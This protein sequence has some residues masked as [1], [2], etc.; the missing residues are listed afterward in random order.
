MFG[1]SGESEEKGYFPHGCANESILTASEQ[2]NLPEKKHF[3]PGR[4]KDKD[5]AEFETWYKEHEND[6]FH[7]ETWAKKYCRQDVRVLAK[8]C[9][10]FRDEI[11]E[12]ADLDPW[13]SSFTLANI[14]SKIFRAD[15]LEDNTIAVVPAHG[16]NKGSKFQSLTALKYLH[17]V[18]RNRGID[19]RTAT[20]VGGE[21]EI[22]G[23]GHVDGF[24]METGNYPHH[25]VL[26]SVHKSKFAAFFAGELHQ[27][28]M[29][30][31]TMPYAPMK[32]VCFLSL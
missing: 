28:R 26:C 1:F 2:P 24:C 30:H 18:S 22:P 32:Y 9:L 16:Y 15:M 21:M 20:N 3:F 25:T 11:M 13:V 7:F 8:A 12:V 19:I 17:W 23:I 31:S 10:A 27:D 5:R 4:L 14:C 29:S 6:P